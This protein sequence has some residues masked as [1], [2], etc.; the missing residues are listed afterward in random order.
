[1][2]TQTQYGKTQREVKETD[3]V[4]EDL[5]STRPARSAGAAVTSTAIASSTTV[6]TTAPHSAVIAAAT[7]GSAGEARLGFS[8]L[9]TTISM[10]NL[11]LVS[12]FE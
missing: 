8:I 11:G 6:S 3:V 9:N 1:M 12:L 4:D 2:L 7:G 5:A 10:G